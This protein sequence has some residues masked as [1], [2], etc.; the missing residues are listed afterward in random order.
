LSHIDIPK[1]TIHIVGIDGIE[2][3]TK[4][5]KEVL[6]KRKDSW[7]TRQNLKSV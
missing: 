4:E 7:K 3:T 1:R 5:V 2:M 6:K